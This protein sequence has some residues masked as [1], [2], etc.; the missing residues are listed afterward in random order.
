MIQEN[1]MKIPWSYDLQNLTKTIKTP[2]PPL[3]EIS[4]QLVDIG[5]KFSRTHFSGTCIKTDAPVKEICDIL[6]E[7]N[8]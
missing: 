2:I 3:D 7:L 6:A 1:N 5:Y 4:V 8:K